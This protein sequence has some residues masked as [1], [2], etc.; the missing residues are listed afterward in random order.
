M[1]DGEEPEL[2]S[3]LNS[4]KNPRRYGSFLPPSDVKRRNRCYT[5]EKG[6]TLAGIALKFD[7]SLESLKVLNKQLYYN[8]KIDVGDRLYVPVV[9]DSEVDN[10][11][12]LNDVD[13]VGDKVVT[14]TNSSDNCRNVE[15]EMVE[16]SNVQSSDTKKPSMY[17]FL[18]KIDSNF[19]KAKNSI[20][21]LAEKSLENDSNW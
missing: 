13:G 21:K 20:N 3:L 4:N 12:G 6:D 18:N 7:T 1:N 16:S 2:T 17:D 15:N 9:K 11:L 10:P 19:S 14:P 5:V 8:S